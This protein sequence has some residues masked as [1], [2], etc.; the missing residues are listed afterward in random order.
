MCLTYMLGLKSVAF[1]T[2]VGIIEVPV[3]LLLVFSSFLAVSV[4]KANS[5]IFDLT[6]KCS[7]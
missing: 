3:K 4:D 6:R 2:D 1:C 7:E 5:L